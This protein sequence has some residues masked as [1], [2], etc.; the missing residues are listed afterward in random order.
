MPPCALEYGNGEGGGHEKGRRKGAVRR[1][2][3]D[4]E[5]SDWHRWITAHLT[6]KKLLVKRDI[7]TKNVSKY[8]HEFPYSTSPRSRNRANRNHPD[9]ASEFLFFPLLPREASKRVPIVDRETGFKPARLTSGSLQA[10][11]SL[12]V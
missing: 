2:L 5:D 6:E 7:H 4:I 12:I 10:D 11:L 1:V 9:Q 3:F 8:T